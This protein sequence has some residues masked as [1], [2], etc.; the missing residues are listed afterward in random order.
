MKPIHFLIGLF[1]ILFGTALF[2][3][4][5]GYK[6][7]HLARLLS[8]I[9]P[10]LLILLGISL[11]W[12]GRIPSGVALALVVLFVGVT[13]AFFLG[14]LQTCSVE[15]DFLVEASTYPSLSAGKLELKFESGKLMLGPTTKQWAEGQFN[16]VA[17][18]TKVRKTNGKLAL[19]IEPED[20]INKRFYG[21]RQRS[22]WNLNIS[23]RLAW[24][25]YINA[26]AVEGNLNLAQIPL[27]HLDMNFG[28]GEL[29]IKLGG[30]GRH[31]VVGIYSGASNLKIL[32][33]ETT[34]L[35]IRLDGAMAKTNLGASGLFMVNNRFVSDNYETANERIDL[36][37]NIGVSNLEIKRIPT[38]PT[39]KTA[40]QEI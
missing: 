2:M 15:T 18:I 28:A 35:R 31:A 39:N 23:P 32:I 24:E 3:S 40:E 19:E 22:V 12:R 16:G 17:A 11:L 13:V 8:V 7:W 1:F 34:G 20:H 6:P 29:E 26:G 10:I 25:I 38:F 37:L 5:L 9:G 21:D 27:H 33:P 14:Y 4:N 36:D 30:N